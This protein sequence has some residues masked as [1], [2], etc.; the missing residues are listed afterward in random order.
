MPSSIATCL[1]LGRKNVMQIVKLYDTDLDADLVDD[2][3]PRKIMTTQD[4]EEAAAYAGLGLP[5]KTLEFG[6]APQSEYEQIYDQT[7]TQDKLMLEFRVSGERLRNDQYGIVKA[8]ARDMMLNFDIKAN[9]DAAD[10]FMNL[11]ADVVNNPVPGLLEAFASNTH[12]TDGPTFSN[13]LTPAE[14]LSPQ[15]LTKMFRLGSQTRAH[16]GHLSPIVGTWDLEVADGNIIPAEMIKF[17]S[18]QAQEMSNNTNRVSKRLGKIIGNPWFVNPE[19]FAIKIANKLRHGC[20]EQVRTK[21]ALTG[22]KYEQS[23]DSF[24]A[25]AMREHVFGILGVRGKVFSMPA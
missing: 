14:T 2:L 12:A 25:T 17:S 16:K 10:R 11:A 21:F 15:A 3:A 7:F 20:F 13:L 24:V 1:K 8:H 6:V 19:W 9:M 23:N 4:F 22:F 18:G 5:V